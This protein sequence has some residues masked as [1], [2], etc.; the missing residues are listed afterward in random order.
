VV[1]EPKKGNLMSFRKLVAASSLSAFLLF[2]VSGPSVGQEQ[3]LDSQST[4]AEHRDTEH[5]FHRNHFG[6]VAGVS[7]H[8]NTDDSGFTLGL[9]YTR[10]FSPKWAVAAYL[11]QVSSK[12]ERDVIVAVGGI[13][14]PIQRLGL[15][16]G[17]GIESVEKDVEVHGTVEQESELELIIRMGVGYGFE[18]TPNAGIGPVI[19]LDRGRDRWTS[20]IAI[21][22]VVG[23]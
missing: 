16:L 13:F 5:E 15:I 21:G 6:G 14:Y 12:L 10:Q 1:E 17:P 2:V 7:T 22:M 3:E 4:D 23:F 9:E 18:L 11:E 8:H 19:M 20:L